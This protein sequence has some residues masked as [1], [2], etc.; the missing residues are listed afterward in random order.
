MQDKKEGL[1]S[2]T[3]EIHNANNKIFKNRNLQNHP[4]MY[5]KCKTNQG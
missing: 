5:Q 1:F 2:A 4:Y 3:P